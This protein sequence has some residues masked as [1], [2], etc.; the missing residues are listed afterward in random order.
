MPTE[1]FEKTI[2]RWRASLARPRQ[3][4][5]SPRSG[6]SMAIL[7]PARSTRCKQSS[8]RPAG[9]FPRRRRSEVSR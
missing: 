1:S 9:I 6:S 3:R 2:R 8:G 7:E 5:R 4:P